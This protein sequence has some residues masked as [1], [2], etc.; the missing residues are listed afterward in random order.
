MLTNG[1][2]KLLTY[3]TEKGLEQ[4]IVRGKH[5]RKVTKKFTVK[6]FPCSFIDFIAYPIAVKHAVV[7]MRFRIA[8]SIV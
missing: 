3:E 7:R 4:C 5:I 2:L 1:E 8:A 6:Q